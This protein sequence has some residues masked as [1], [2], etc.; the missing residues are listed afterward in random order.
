MPSNGGI[1]AIV[2]NILIFFEVMCYEL[3]LNDTAENVD[4]GISIN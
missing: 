2:Y 3:W 1:E 4:D